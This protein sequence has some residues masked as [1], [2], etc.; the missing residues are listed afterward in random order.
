MQVFQKNVERDWEKFLLHRAAELKPGTSAC[1]CEKDKIFK[2]FK[3]PSHAAGYMQR[4]A[5]QDQHFN[6]SKQ[7][8]DIKYCEIIYIYTLSWCSYF[9]T[10]YSI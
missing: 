7:Y 9:K 1:E 8:K 5:I 2:V 6:L 3:K 10:L 4:I